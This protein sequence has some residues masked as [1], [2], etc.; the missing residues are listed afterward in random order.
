MG[1]EIVEAEDLAPKCEIP[2]WHSLSPR[3]S[4]MDFK[5]TPLGRWMT[6]LSIMSL[7]TIGFAP[8]GS[9]KVHKTLLK[10]ADYLV[11]G[12]KEEIFTPMYF[13]LARKPLNNKTASY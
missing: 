2:W 9:S 7:E 10:A 5:S 13:V 11:K 8:R 6:H 12:G 3:W 1:F 4:I